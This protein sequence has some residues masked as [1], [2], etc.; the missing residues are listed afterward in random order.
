MLTPLFVIQL[1]LKI[2]KKTGKFKLG[3]AS[4]CSINLATHGQENHPL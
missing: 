1:F 2:N 3:L 4:S